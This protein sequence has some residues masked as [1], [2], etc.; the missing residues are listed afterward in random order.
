MIKALV[1]TCILITTVTA[2]SAERLRVR[3]GEH[4]D[5]TRLVVQ[6][7]LG[8]EWNLR[9]L[10]N[11]AELS[12]ALDGAVYETDTVFN[13][14]YGH[15]LTS[16]SQKRSGSSLELAF[17]CD[18]VATAFLF[19]GT[20]IVVDIAP[21]QF[22]SPL[23]L[24]Q[25]KLTKRRPLKAQKQVELQPKKFEIPLLNLSRQDLETQMMSRILQGADREV[26][27]LDL[28]DVGP[29]R[30]TA[31][32]PE[33]IASDL[34][35]NL[36]VTSILDELR[37]LGGFLEPPFNSI[38]A[39]ITDAEL[40]FDA[41]H[42]TQQFEHQVAYLRSE[43]FE[44]FD[45]INT[46]RALEL[47]KLYAYHGFGA[48]A[49]QVLNLLPEQSE[50]TSR[51]RAI[52]HA[53]DERP[54]LESHPF[55]HQQRCDGITALWSV[56]I[57]KKLDPEAELYA[58]EKSFSLLPDHLRRQFGPTLM[59][60]LAK[61]GKLEESRR[62]MRSVERLDLEDRNELN[63]ARA[64]IAD[65][66]G[67]DAL[68]ETL[69][70]EVAATA[71]AAEESALALARLIEKRWSDRKPVSQQNI[72]LAAAYAVELR[73]SEFGP[74]MKRAHALALGLNHDFDRALSLIQSSTT[75]DGWDGTQ[76]QVLQL[77]AERADDITY[78]RHALNL[79]KAVV[80]QLSTE[81]AIALSKRLAKLGFAQQAF[82]LA[83]RS[84]DKLRRVDRTRLRAQAALQNGRPH[85]ALLE[86]AED[87][88]DEANRI[89]ADA[90]IKIE[91]FS[92][93][94][95]ILSELG[96]TGEAARYL[97][98]AGLVDEASMEASGRFGDLARLD[99]AL[100]RKIERIPAKPLADATAL[101]EQSEQTRGLITNMLSAA[102]VTSSQ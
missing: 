51:I 2:A 68:A 29:R 53:M 73:R 22:L 85:Q 63:L 27:D 72:D 40:D 90:Y 91:E 61:A 86:L 19:R 88:S 94:A 102:G 69:L 58:I 42:G 87:D 95:T 83:N 71:M 49:V 57:E 30:S 25:S 82:N 21:G 47:A 55:S 1:L 93:A 76:S 84:E 31:I 46:E 45:H 38:P 66:G 74:K 50:I 100:G 32:D 41:W 18:C 10:H 89:K 92:Q 23:A 16:V 54:A 52:A 67:E 65:A 11:G 60:T 33:V 20:M 34:T 36:Q 79:P 78:L 12:V 59:D 14:L 62:V 43:L 5:F 75:D 98:L 44:E 48:E 97:W 24:I 56:L 77:L 70:S 39:C 80:G 26:V 64:S 35:A 17:G 37:G 4:K 8:T 81:T 7:P 6:I 28:S 9:Q 13:R 99:K 15:R 96:E 3:S 101:L